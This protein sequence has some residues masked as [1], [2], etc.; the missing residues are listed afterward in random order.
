MKKALLLFLLSSAVFVTT[1]QLRK[2]PA[3]VTEAFAS[4]Y[5]HATRV[6]WK[7]KLHY[8]EATFELNGS[9]I[10]ADFSSKGEWQSSERKLNFDDLPDEVV[11]QQL[12]NYG[13]DDNVFAVRVGR[14]PLQ[15]SGCN[16]EQRQHQSDHERLPH[17]R[18]V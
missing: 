18:R 9:I 8:F 11:S 7:D 12:G 14:Q 2:I 10:A 1:A 15:V 16:D 5:P 3:D 6:E 17:T 13:S 4:R